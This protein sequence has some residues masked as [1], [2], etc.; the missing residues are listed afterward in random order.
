MG[1]VKNIVNNSLITCG[2]LALA[3]VFCFMLQGASTTDSHV[4]LIF[5]LSV[6]CI[7]RFTTGY[8]YG[9]LASL[10]AVI[11]VNY[12]FTYPYFELNF[13]ITGYPLTFLVMFAVSVIVSALTSQIKCQE[14][15]NLEIERE[16]IRS[17]LFR[18]V[19]HDIR[20]PLT[21]IVGMAST[22]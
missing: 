5:V 7:S 14:K 9:I 2:F 19:S 20:T 13:T 6:L 11:A 16:K 21:A 3:S 18:S 4:P 22:V 15:I 17:N 10:I 1:N 12:V 8:I